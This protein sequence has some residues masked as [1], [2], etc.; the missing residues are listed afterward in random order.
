[1]ERFE[2]AHFRN[3]IPFIDLKFHKESPIMNVSNIKT[4]LMIWV[5]LEDISVDPKH[6]IKLFAALWRLGKESIFIRYPDEGHVI[7]K[8]EN[9]YDISKKTIEWFNYHL[10]NLP[11]GKW[12]K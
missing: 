9:Q 4:P 1:M 11:P 5:G 10:K 6:S 2:I 8:E 12:M 3:K 7:I